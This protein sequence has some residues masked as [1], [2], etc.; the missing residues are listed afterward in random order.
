MIMAK[1]TEP[2]DAV[3][4]KLVDGELSETERRELLV[5]LDDQ[6]GG[7]RRCA[8][9]FLES[10]CWKRSLAAFGNAASL[11]Q[12]REEQP[13]KPRLA[14]QPLWQTAGTM[15]AMAASF[16]VALGLV[17]WARQPRGVA[18]LGYQPGS[19]IAKVETPAAQLPSSPAPWRVV[20]VSEGQQPG[21]S[22]NVAA[23]ERE[24]IDP[25]WLQ[26]VPSAIPD[27]V[28]QALARTGHQV[29]QRRD[30]VRATLPDGR[31]LLVPVDQVQVHYV[32]NQV[33]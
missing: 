10:Q 24:S 7:W 29:Q 1:N 25:K 32:G 3:F 18:P 33:Y 13:A 22:F 12:R 21:D 28:L 20:S 5:S 6:P 11:P 9:A 14:K 31:R 30:V 8:L 27:N 26:S 19:D 2:T 15:S 4:D 23:K 16:L 17:F